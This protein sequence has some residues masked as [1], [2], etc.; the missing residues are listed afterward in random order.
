MKLEAA[1]VGFF[2]VLASVAAAQQPP[3][4][5]NRKIDEFVRLLDDPDVR[6][7]LD[8]RRSENPSSAPGA[9]E[10]NFALVKWEAAVR[11]RVHNVLTAI[12]RIPAEVGTAA[13]RTREEAI[14]RGY[15]PVF[16]IFAGLVAIGLIAELIWRR[17]VAR[18]NDLLARLGSLGGYGLF[19]G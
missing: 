3:S 19:R 7:W 12:P 11:S 16:A 9:A 1:I 15:S 13:V 18:N 17:L 2:L 5:T 4:E 14:A 8:S 10:S 6:A